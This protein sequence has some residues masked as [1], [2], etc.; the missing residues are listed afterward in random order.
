[1]NSSAIEVADDGDAAR[2]EAL[3]DAGEPRGIDGVAE[4]RRHRQPARGAAMSPQGRRAA[5]IQRAASSSVSTITSGSHPGGGSALRR[6]RSRCAPARRARRRS[7][8]RPTSS[9]LSPTT[10]E[11]ADVEIQIGGRL[12]HHARR[13]LAAAARDAI[14]VDDAVRVMRTV[15]IPVHDGP[16][17]RSSASRRACAACTNASSKTPRAM[18]AWLVTITTA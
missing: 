15:I 7:C 18:P 3:D 1:M 6:R 10:N 13:R 8:A 2:R 16:L 17:P 12:L 11:R 14:P 5:R 9:H 4:R